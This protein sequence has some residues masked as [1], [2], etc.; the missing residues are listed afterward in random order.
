MEVKA[1]ALAKLKGTEASLNLEFWTSLTSSEQ[2]RTR[3]WDR[4]HG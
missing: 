1:A 3:R 4:H 2:A